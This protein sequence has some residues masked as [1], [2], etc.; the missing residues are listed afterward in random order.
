MSKHAKRANSAWARE[1]FG[2]A[3]LGDVRRTE[4]LVAMG[5][6][7]CEG[8]SGT[9]AS[10]F[11]EDRELQGAYDFLENPAVDAREIVGSTAR[12]TT[13]RV[14]R[15]PYVFV[16]IDGTSIQISDWRRQRDF[17]RIGSDSNGSRGLK[18]VD[19]LAVEPNGTVAGWLALTFWARSD[20]KLP[21]RGTEARRGRAL[22]ER[23][24]RH[25]IETVD[26][27]RAALDERGVRGWFQIDREGDGR[28]LLTAL[29][30]S[31]HWWTVRANHDRSIELEGGTASRLRTELAK[32]RT[33]GR[34]K[35][36]VRAGRDR[37]A[38]T[39]QMIVRTARVVLRL[40]DRRTGRI[41]RFAVTVVWALEAGTTPAREKP[42][43]WLLYTNHPVDSFDDAKLVIDGYAQ[44][45]RVEE[46]HRAWKRTGCDVESTQLRSFAAVQ[47]W[48]IILLVVAARIERLKRL[49]RATPLEPAT[50]AFSRFEIQAMTMMLFEDRPQPE[51]EPTLG[52]ATRWL[53][54]I[55]GWANKYSK[56]KPHPGA[57]VLG[58][59][60]ERIR[61]PARFLEVASKRGK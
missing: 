43:D 15:Q 38:R 28:D 17:G 3:D 47:R 44:R 49:S 41:T 6:R 51:G 16:P 25:W 42:L 55:G 30:A 61:I 29:D 39:A 18:L 1:E 12:A 4:R 37:R 9:V 45:W 56:T 58:R 48:A 40:R 60:L 22:E 26:A 13:A 34:Y 2:G 24:T 11:G 5:A 27:A 46:C 33:T 19:A 14:A 20:H 31:A 50:V 59:G 54:E 21:P 57:V 53:A 36:P 7:A 23:E 8:P 52:Q 35:L 10:V 32:R